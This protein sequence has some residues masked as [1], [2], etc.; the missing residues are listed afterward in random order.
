[1]KSDDGDKAADG[2][3][4]NEGKNIILKNILINNFFSESSSSNSSCTPVQVYRDL[5]PARLELDG[6]V[7]SRFEER[8]GV[9]DTMGKVVVHR[10]GGGRG[11]K[12]C[13]QVG[14]MEWV[15]SLSAYLRQSQI[16]YSSL[17]QSM[18]WPCVSRQFTK[19]FIVESSSPMVVLASL[20]EARWRSCQH[21]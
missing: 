18:M 13:D 2:G 6:G 7:H 11:V 5:V 21:F 10:P 8:W 15:G 14:Q 19:T 4:D 3:G 1:M 17:V 20:L 16:T 9:G 12:H